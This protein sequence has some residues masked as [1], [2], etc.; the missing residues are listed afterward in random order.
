MSNL[1]IIKNDELSPEFANVNGFSLEDDSLI[2][3]AKYVGD[4]SQYYKAQDLVLKSNGQN[5]LLESA[6]FIAGA[7]SK[8][9]WDDYIVYKAIRGKLAQ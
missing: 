4:A 5:Y 3:T 1:N 6:T 7:A 9:D 8:D 2:F